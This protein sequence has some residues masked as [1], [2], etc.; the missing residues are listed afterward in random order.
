[1]GES[2]HES[3]SWDHPTNGNETYIN[4]IY[5]CLGGFTGWAVHDECKQYYWCNNGTMERDIL[6]CA[7]N[8]LFDVKHGICKLSSEVQCNKTFGIEHN[9]T[10]TSSESAKYAWPEPSNA[11]V[12]TDEDYLDEWYSRTQVFLDTSSVSKQKTISLLPF[13]IILHE[14]VM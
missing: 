2:K 14:L 12:A 13:I 1:M 4:E 6:H 7:D 9:E 11:D 8:L 3:E 5:E 10:L